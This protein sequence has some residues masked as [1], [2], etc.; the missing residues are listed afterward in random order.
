MARNV[1][2]PIVV[3]LA[4]LGC[5]GQ[6]A[7]VN[8]IQGE[9]QELISTVEKER[10]D[11]KA[12]QQRT[13][14]LE[15]RLDQSEKEI[16]RLTGRKSNWDDSSLR[17]ASSK[18]S[19][20]NNPSQANTKSPKTLSGDTKLLPA[21]QPLLW[22]APKEIPSSST[23]PATKPPGEKTS[24]SSSKV[25]PTVRGLSQR[26][27]RLQYDAATD[28][29]RYQMEITFEENGA[30]LTAQGRKRLDDLASWL[31]ADAT[32]ELRVLVSGSSTGM[33]KPK[34]GDEKPRFAN[35]RQLGAARAG[36]VADYLDR[37]GIFADRLVVLGSGSPQFDPE[38]TSTSPVQI[39]L[40]DAKA[41]VMGLVPKQPALRR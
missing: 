6:N 13:A 39:Y 31:K 29:A 37:H 3:L 5:A 40:A 41:A 14:S 23:K 24:E 7:Q 19:S 30:G 16:A 17:S 22:K 35:D 15:A 9:K 4:P 28:T 25:T 27:P 38:V 12:L 36:A 18:S 21:E 2:I 33:K 20:A 10:A 26:D 1:L 8:R 32:K 11:K 34:A